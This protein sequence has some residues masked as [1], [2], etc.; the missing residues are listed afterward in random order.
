MDT[1]E[2]PICHPYANL[3]TANQASEMAENDMKAYSTLGENLIM[4][5][6]G[7]NN[8]Y[9]IRIIKMLKEKSIKNMIIMMQ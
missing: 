8:R 9:T 1:T 6:G 5:T 2:S 3:R 4:D 7:I